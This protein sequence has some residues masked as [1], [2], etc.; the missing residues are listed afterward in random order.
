MTARTVLLAAAFGLALIAL[1]A[2]SGLA[3][4]C[5]L[6]LPETSAY[7]ET[8]DTTDDCTTSTNPPIRQPRRHRHRRHHHALWMG[9][10]AALVGA[11]LHDDDDHTPATFVP[12]TNSHPHDT[13]GY[14]PGYNPGWNPGSQQQQQQTW[15]G[16]CGKFGKPQQQG[17]YR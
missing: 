12:E 7:L 9:L 11:L 3:R 14:N 4:D 1:S 15:P 8:P 10:G 2:V 6:T 16:D 13:P 5:D 17:Q